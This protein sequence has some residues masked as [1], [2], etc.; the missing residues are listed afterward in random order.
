MQTLLVLNPF[1]GDWNCEN[2]C[3][4]SPKKRG[5]DSI[6]GAK[7]CARYTESSSSVNSRP[8]VLLMKLHFPYKGEL[9]RQVRDLEP[10]ER[11]PAFNGVMQLAWDSEIQVIRL[12]FLLIIFS[13]PRD[14]LSWRTGALEAFFGACK[15]FSEQPPTQLVEGI[16][17]FCTLF[18]VVHQSQPFQSAVWAFPRPSGPYW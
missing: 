10:W 7:K 11:R 9:L 4:L 18:R 17:S 13:V 2:E 3:F 5:L 6:F 16:S 12:C 15:E 1:F 14:N 8:T